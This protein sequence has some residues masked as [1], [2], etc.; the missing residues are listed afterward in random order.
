MTREKASFDAVCFPI[1]LLERKNI[2]FLLFFGKYLTYFISCVENIRIF[3]LC[4]ALVNLLIFSSHS[5]KF[6]WY[7]PRKSKYP[8]CIE[9]QAS[10]ALRIKNRTFKT[11]DLPYFLT[12]SAIIFFFEWVIVMW[13]LPLDNCLYEFYIVYFYNCNFTLSIVKYDQNLLLLI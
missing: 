13:V 6:V 1:F 5:M 10:C 8:L 11:P 7:S 9:G 3:T 12:W 4:C 2:F